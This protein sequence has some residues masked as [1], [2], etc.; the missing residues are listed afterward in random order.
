MA[1]NLNNLALLYAST[2]RPAEAAPLCQRALAILEARLGPDD[3]NTRT[4]RAN[5][6]ALKQALADQGMVTRQLSARRPIRSGEFQGTEGSQFGPG[7]ERVASTRPRAGPE[8]GR[9]NEGE[10]DSNSRPPTSST[11][12]G[13]RNA[14]RR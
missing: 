11:P 9:S 10:P 4:V 6:E 1:R 13:E 14:H 2:G 12:L 7:V 5:L 3:P 8:D